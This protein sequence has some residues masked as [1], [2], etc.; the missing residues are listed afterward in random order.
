MYIGSR[1]FDI[2]H[3]TYVMGILNVTPD[4]FS[5]GGKYNQKDAA[6]F[7]AAEM[8]REGA[9]LID[10][11]GESTRPGYQRISEEEEIERVLPVIEGIKDSFDIPVSLDTYKSAVAK[12]G[13]EAGVDLLNDIWGLLYD[14]S[15]GQI[16]AKNRTAYC[17]MHNRSRLHET[18]VLEDF[19]QA[20]REDIKRAE[21][22]GILPEQ[23]ILDPGIGFAK[24]QEQ[25][26]MLI[27]NLDAIGALGYPV[28]LGASRKSV[29]EYVLDEPIENRLEGTLATTAEAVFAH[30]GFVR[31]HDVK[32]HARFIRML[33]RTRETWRGHGRNFY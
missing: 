4:S 26:L 17:L 1:E 15:L 9:S 27:G 33:E 31:V 23:I 25:N 11:G 14:Q 20:M 6:L 13:V 3:H 5:D 22:F 10:I 28:L 12:A 7:R 32:E 16:A 21:S 18:W 24:T 19:I 2:A 30:C 8:I 29:V